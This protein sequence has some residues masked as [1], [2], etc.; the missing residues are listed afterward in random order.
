MI[1][2]SPKW[3]LLFYNGAPCWATEHRVWFM[4]GNFAAMHDVLDYIFGAASFVP[5]GY[6]LL[7]RSDLVAMHA[8][9]DFIT[10]ISYFSI[11]AAIHVFII[12]RR[13][14][15][16][17]WLAWLFVAFIS[18]CGMTHLVSLVTLWEPI[19]GL[20][21][22]VKLGA[23]GVSLVTA[24]VMWPLLPK[25][26][27]LPS[28]AMLREAND[29]LHAE[30][31]QRQ[32]AEADLLQTHQQLERRVEERTQ[33]LRLANDQ[34]AK[35]NA[36]HERALLRLQSIL[37][38]TVDALIT[39]DDSGTI[40]DYNLACERMF[41][42][43]A[44][45]TVGGNVK[46]LMAPADAQQH[47]SHLQ[48]YAATGSAKIIGIERE[49]NGRRKDGTLVPL[50]LSVSEIRLCNRRLFSGILRDISERKEAEA[51]RE[52][53]VG[54]LQASN[55]ELEQFAYIASHDLRAPLRALSI[56][57]KW[58]KQD[59]D[60]VGGVPPSIEEHLADM[61]TQ[62]DRM[63]RLLTDLL[64]Y[65]RIGRAQGVVS[66]IDPR[67]VVESARALLQ[68]PP[69]FDLA[70]ETDLPIVA[71]I[72]TEFEL[73]VRNLISNAVK[74][75]DRDQGRIVVRGGR[76]E[77]DAFFEVRD[78]G[79]GIGPEYHQRIFEMFSTLRSRDEVEGSGIGLA[80]IKKI[81]E[82]WGGRVSVSSKRDERGTTFRFTMPATIRVAA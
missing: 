81:V 8:T 4:S 76:D 40:E 48:D 38:N 33:Q 43:T 68:I 39:I 27:A 65:S 67:S 73:V 50:E 72:P 23:A 37:D 25:A 79:P 71:A 77:A 6:C 16:Y 51:Q 61:R 57:P 2:T 74:H 28:P 42:F 35:L 3:T 1:M 36:D 32:R 80:L 12:R 26:L 41:G 30:I 10:A 78:D 49:V 5:H 18:A 55:Q 11:P 47:D 29:K 69:S 46:M 70:I 45:E 14:M 52:T 24:I 13:D 17:S 62:V 60:N 66:T 82:R 31:A 56:L 34:L 54:Q 21:G 58:I 59:L 20:Q 64:E 15:D 22:L 7:W 63:D 75:H 19:Y 9:A 53:L 44:A